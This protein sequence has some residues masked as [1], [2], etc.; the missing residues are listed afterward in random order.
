M[1]AGEHLSQ[2]LKALAIAKPQR[3]SWLLEELYDLLV[4]LDEDVKVERS[5]FRDVLLVLSARLQ[6]REI[7]RAAQLMEF[8]FMSRLVPGTKV[9]RAT[10]PEELYRALEPLLP[11]GRRLK[12]MVSLRGRGKEVVREEELERYVSSRGNLLSRQS[13]EVLVVESIGEVFVLSYGI[14]H[15]CGLSCTLVVPK[16]HNAF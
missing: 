13:R 10:R 12:L 3:E 5:G 2:L 14:T 4:P 11:S 1:S 15:K 7:C 8:S 16:E 6:P 9:A